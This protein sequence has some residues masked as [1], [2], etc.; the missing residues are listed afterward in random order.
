MTCHKCGQVGH[1]VRE[2]TVKVCWTCHQQGHFA[3]TCPLRGEIAE[4]IK[5]QS[6]KKV[7]WA[8]GISTEKDPRITEVRDQAIEKEDQA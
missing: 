8:E 7:Y 2:C 4:L 5:R 3:G 6:Q 1:G